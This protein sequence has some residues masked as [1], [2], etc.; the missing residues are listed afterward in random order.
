MRV[1]GR[2]HVAVDVAAG[3]QRVE[4]RGVD[5]LHGAA[6]VRLDD[7]VELE[8]LPRRQPQRA[9]GVVG[10]DPVERQPLRRRDDAAGD[11]HADHEAEGLLQ[12][13]LGA[14]AAHV[15]VVLQIGAVERDEIWSSSAMA[16]VATSS[17][18]RAIVPRSWRLASLMCS[19]LE[20]LSVMGRGSEWLVGSR[21]GSSTSSHG[22]DVT[23]N[24]R[25]ADSGR[26]C[27]APRDRRRRAR[28]VSALSTSRAIAFSSPQT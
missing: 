19:F 25:R 15:A 4:Q 11:A 18:P 28:R 10:R 21:S 17:R 26:P 1:R 7:A 6:H 13:L 3:G 14:L 24:R 20:R 9:V 5:R 23:L 22:H 16:P 2:E 27:A 12:P 8:R